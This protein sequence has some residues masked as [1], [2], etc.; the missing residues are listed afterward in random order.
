[1]ALR[2]EK[3]CVAILIVDIQFHHVVAEEVPVVIGSSQQLMLTIIG[4]RVHVAHKD[5]I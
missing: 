4:K 5:F 2:V 1:V 3:I